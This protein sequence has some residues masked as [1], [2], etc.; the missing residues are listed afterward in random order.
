VFLCQIQQFERLTF[1]SHNSVLEC[2]FPAALHE[3]LKHIGHIQV[4]PRHKR[5]CNNK[6]VGLMPN[7]ISIEEEHWHCVHKV[8]LGHRPVN[9]PAY[10][11][12]VEYHLLYDP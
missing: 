4:R 3:H 7:S 6:Q 10:L 9:K 2:T 8:L 11:N 5:G 1:P 12:E